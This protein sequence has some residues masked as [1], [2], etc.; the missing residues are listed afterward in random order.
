MHADRFDVMW[1]HPTGALSTT[2]KSADVAKVAYAV[3]Y[4]AAAGGVNTPW[5]EIEGSVAE[6]GAQVTV[7]GL[8]SGT[9]YEVV[10]E[11]RYADGRV[12]RGET[13]VFR[14]ADASTVWINPHRVTE[15]DLTTVDFLANHN[16]GTLNADVGFITMGGMLL[17]PSC[18]SSLVLALGSSRWGMHSSLLIAIAHLT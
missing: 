13:D 9:A 6:K 5:V 14:T 16:S 10:V 8:V 1:D 18:Y 2:A 7:S 17:P 3:L 15:N 4:R 11:A 12:M